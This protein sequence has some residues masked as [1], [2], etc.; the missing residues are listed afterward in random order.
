MKEWLTDIFM[1]SPNNHDTWCCP[2]S[3][4]MSSGGGPEWFSVVRPGPRLQPVCPSLRSWH[5]TGASSAAP[6]CLWSDCWDSDITAL[7]GAEV[8][9]VRKI[10]QTQHQLV[11]ECSGPRPSLYLQTGT[12]MGLSLISLNWPLSMRAW[13]TAF[14]AS[15]RFMPW[16]TTLDTLETHSSRRRKRIKMQ[17]PRI[18]H[19]KVNFTT[20]QPS[21]Q[22]KA[23]MLAIRNRTRKGGGTLM[24]WPFSSRMLMKARLCLTPTS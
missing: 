13:S 11:R 10:F 1:I 14:L 5:T 4:T 17:Q 12:T 20:N 7:R 9:K 16:K 2:S 21:K 15:K 3:W 23:L 18:V 22:A 24:S 6:Q 19:K 8:L